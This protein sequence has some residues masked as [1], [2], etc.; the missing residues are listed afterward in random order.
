MPSAVCP[1]ADGSS[2]SDCGVNI[3][4]FMNIKEYV[5][6]MA[7]IISTVAEMQVLICDTDFR[8]IGDSK[9]GVTNCEEFTD[10]TENSMLVETIRRRKMIIV[11]D[12]KNHFEGCLHCPSR[13]TCDVNAMISIPV[14]DGSRIYGGIGLYANQ[15]EDIKRLMEK[16]RDFIEFIHRISEL[17][18]MKLK[19]EG[20]NQQLRETV[21][22]L[23]NYSCD[24][25]FEDIIGSSRIISE[26]KAEA[27]RFAEGNS[28][29]LITGESGTGKEVF[30]RAIHTASRC[31]GGP[32]V[33]INCAALPENLI[34]SELFGYEEGAFT[35]ALKG[36]KLGKFELADG[37]T[38]FL[39]EIGEFPIHLQAK[40][41]RALQE[42]KIQRVGGQKEIPVK[43]RLIAATNRDL[44]EQVENGQ[45]REGLYY[46]LSVIPIQLPPL[47]LRRG[48]IEE[49]AEHFL[50]IYAK[51]LRKDVFG[52]EPGAL[53]IL[54]EYPWP[55]NIR[56]LQNAVE[57]AV[58]I[59]GG[60]YI[61]ARDLPKK[62][63]SGE[64]RE[65]AEG[66][67][68]LRPLRYVEDDYIREALRVYGCTLEGK[69]QAARVLGISKATLYRRIKEIEEMKK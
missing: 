45:F 1:A 10:L 9:G 32:F 67:L 49:L 3:M 8:I 34:E 57:Y 36:G 48:D 68:T 16:H 41:L 47:R 6:K 40:L 51:A 14:I 15:K 25:A 21:K 61:E 27:R 44:E 63:L 62:L 17:L 50:H 42:K 22:K 13:E 69:L 64:Q 37:G 26:V 12:S 5:Q 43:V 33:P 66:S 2:L 23:Q 58:N 30:A 20:Q 52:L 53:R 31:S 46:R 55:G 24:M 7:G 19:E 59:T 54:C 11:E 29:I 39:D 56:E 35:G 60:S 28:N 38:L 18:I 65:S 4:D